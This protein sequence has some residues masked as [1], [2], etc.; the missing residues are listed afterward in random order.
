MIFSFFYLCFMDKKRLKFIIPSALGV[1]LFITPIVVGEEVTIPIAFLTKLIASFLKETTPV[2]ALII[3]GF[4]ALGGHLKFGKKEKNTY[5]TNLLYPS[6][7]WR[8]VRYVGFI[9]LI[10]AV[11]KIGGEPFWGATTGGL[12]LNDLFPILLAVFFIVGI[13]LPLLLNFGL[14]EFVGTMMTRIMRPL[15]CLPGRS[16]I[17]CIASWLGDG[18]IGILMANKQYIDGYYTEKEASIIGTTFS[19]VSITFSLVVIETV[20]LGF[21]FLPF[22]ATVS[23]AGFIT[24]LIIPRIPPLSRKKNIYFN[25]SPAKESET[26]PE[27]MKP[28][29]WGLYLAEKKADENKNISSFFIEGSKNVLDMWVGV[30]PI[31]MA[32]GTFS[33]MLAEY[34]PILQYLGLPFEPLLNFMGVPEAQEASQTMMVGFA[35]MFIPSIL[36]SV[37]ISSAMT[38]FIVAA[39]SVSQLIYMSEVGGL[40]LGSKIPV[41]FWNLFVIF[42]E[43]TLITLPIIVIMAKIIF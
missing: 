5:L 1:F 41:S 17:N 22:Y 33:L 16:S 20:G 10:M 18:S 11:F 42:I 27:N 25:N 38:R 37:N 24:A 34:T 9:F 21:M 35:D 36:A 14:L 40:L 8:I 6:K 32:V 15:F 3:V 30:L 13:L 43:R 19:A 7:A 29:A 2:L 12:I 23:I 39:V 28:S 31:V 4:S 26:I